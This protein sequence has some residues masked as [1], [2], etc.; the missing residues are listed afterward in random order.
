MAQSDRL[1]R[2]LVIFIHLLGLASSALALSLEDFQ[3]ITS[4]QISSSCIRIYSKDIGSCSEDDFIE[5]NQCSTRCQLGL[6]GIQ[7]LVQ[8]ACHDEVVNPDSLLGLTLEGQLIGAVCSQSHETTVT[9]TIPAATTTPGNGGGGGILTITQTSTPEVSTTTSST[10]NTFTKTTISTS[11]TQNTVTKTTISTSST[12]DTTAIVTTTT[13]SD[14]STATSTTESPSATEDSSN[15]DDD[16]DNDDDDDNGGGGRNTG[17]GSPFDPQVPQSLGT[18]D[19]P[20][21]NLAAVLATLS[22]VMIL[23]R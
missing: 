12:T 9:T 8:L 10:Q 16:S 21:S 17:G 20:K 23:G 13:A 22:L 2:P 19:R 4:N 11:S 18:H 1:R 14:T 15:D 7:T 5:G 6:F 3:I